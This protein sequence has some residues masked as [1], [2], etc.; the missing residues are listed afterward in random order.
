MEMT[1]ANLFAEFL[2]HLPA[3]QELEFRTK[4]SFDLLDVFINA[5]LPTVKRITTACP[6]PDLLNAFSE[7]EALDALVLERSIE[8]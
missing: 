4:V 3:L 7:R 8:L 6:S 1:E 5:V 2:R